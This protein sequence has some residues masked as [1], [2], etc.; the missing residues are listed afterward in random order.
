MTFETEYTPVE[1]SWGR[2]TMTMRPK[3]ILTVNCFD[4]SFAKGKIGGEAIKASYCI[5]KS[6]ISLRGSSH[7]G[8]SWQTK[9]CDSFL[10]CKNSQKLSLGK[11]NRNISDCSQVAIC[12]DSVPVLWRSMCKR[13]LRT[14]SSA[15]HPSWKAW[16][17]KPVRSFL[18]TSTTSFLPL[19]VFFLWEAIHSGRWFTFL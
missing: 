7:S 1:Y 6:H 9:K 4:S 13:I 2:F 11:K 3:K 14:S 5:A 16:S 10:L 12:R 15:T 19:W 17:T 18:T 8:G